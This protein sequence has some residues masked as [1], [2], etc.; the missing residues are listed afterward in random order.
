MKGVSSVISAG[1]FYQPA[2]FLKAKSFGGVGKSRDENKGE[3][4]K[5]ERDSL[6]IAHLGRKKVKRR[7]SGANEREP[8]TGLSRRRAGFAPSRIA[9]RLP[10]P[11]PRLW[12]SMGGGGGRGCNSEWIQIRF[13]G[14]RLYALDRLKG[15]LYVCVCVHF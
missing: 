15:G 8:P 5:A 11:P 6:R 9:P 2:T 13:T 4:C 7:E 12:L 10:L 3:S 1:D 14:V